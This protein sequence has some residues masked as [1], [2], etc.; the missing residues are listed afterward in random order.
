MKIIFLFLLS[1][2]LN[3]Q[4][5]GQVVANNRVL[6]DSLLTSSLTNDTSI[7]LLLFAKLDSCTSCQSCLRFIQRN[8]LA[9]LHIAKDR[10]GVTGYRQLF[11]EAFRKEC[12]G[13]LHNSALVSWYY[14]KADTIIDYNEK[15]IEERYYTRSTLDS[16][17]NFCGREWISIMR[18]KQNNSVYN[19]VPR[20]IEM[21]N[22]CIKAG[23]RKIQRQI[24]K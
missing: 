15:I 10:N 8:R 19:V 3:G 5:F 11:H 12:A 24:K 4:I 17:G 13:F 18:Q 6:F 1:Y 23:K 22:P 7:G 2:L 21:C 20:Y 9:S 16:C 14:N